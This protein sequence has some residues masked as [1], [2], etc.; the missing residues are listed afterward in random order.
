[1]SDVEFGLMLVAALDAIHASEPD[2]HEW[3]SRVLH[4]DSTLCLDNHGR[5]WILVLRRHLPDERVAASETP[6]AKKQR[7]QNE[8]VAVSE[9]SEASQKSVE[10]GS[11][12]T[13]TLVLSAFFK[14]AM[15]HRDFCFMLGDAID[16][17]SSGEHHA[18]EWKSHPCNNGDVFSLG[19][20]G[21]NWLLELG[22]EAKGNKMKGCAG[23]SNA[24]GN[25]WDA[26]AG[27]WQRWKQGD[28][29]GGEAHGR[30]TGKL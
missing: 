6:K 17:I 9:K 7:L 2:G 24:S 21:V 4:D 29:K 23:K 5:D 19:D 22:P 15:S 3:S 25:S 12:M 30:G 14:G 13:K 26:Q 20:L 8:M 18:R 10:K 11:A 1:M 27:N 16:A 28:A